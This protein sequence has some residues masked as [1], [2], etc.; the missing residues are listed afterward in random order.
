MNELNVESSL[1]TAQEKSDDKMLLSSVTM[2]IC[3]LCS[4]EE[5]LLLSRTKF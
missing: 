1:S 2:R 4:Q 3:M 5:R